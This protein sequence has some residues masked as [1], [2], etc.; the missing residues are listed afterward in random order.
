MTTLELKYRGQMDDALEAELNQIMRGARS[1]G[2][3]YYFAGKTRDMA[4]RLP[5]VRLARARKARI[6]EAC[7]RAGVRAEVTVTTSERYK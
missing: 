5:N 3:G 7:R 1:E 2:S 6:L 4:W